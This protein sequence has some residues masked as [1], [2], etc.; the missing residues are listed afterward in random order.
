MVLSSLDEQGNKTIVVQ[1]IYIIRGG[2]M[3][4]DEER[5]LF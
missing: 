3:I 5:I 4:K 2:F 1:M